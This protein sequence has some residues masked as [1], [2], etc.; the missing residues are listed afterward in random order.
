MSTNFKIA[1]FLT[2]AVLLAACEGDD[3]ANGVDGA[4]GTDGLNSLVAT[5]DIPK[6][7]A[8]CLGGGLALDSGLDTNRNGVLDADEVTATE[9]LE[10]EATPTARALHASPDAPAVNV[11]VN[12]EVALPGVDF[13]Q[14]SG[15]L[16]VIEEN[17]IEIE[18]IT[19][20]GNAV[21]LTI[22]ANLD[23]NTEATV[24]AVGKVADGTLDALAIVNPSDSPITAGSFRAQVVHGA[25]SAPPV[26][27]YV[28]TLDADLAGSAPVN[29]AGTPLAFG[30][31]TPQLEVT[32]GNYQVR[33]TAAGDPAAVV[34][35]SGEFSFGEGA[36]LMIVA[37]D[38]T[39]P[40]SSPVELVALDGTTGLTIKDA[41]TPASVVAAHLSP[42]APAVDILA[43]VNS[44]PEDEALKL[45]SNISFP[46]ACELGSVPAPGDYTI[47]VAANADNSVVPASFG[48][49]VEQS[50]EVTAIVSGFLAMGDP[51]IAALE[52]QIDDRRSIATETKLRITHASPSTGDVDL[53]LV[54]AGTDINNAE[55]AFP[56]VPF[57]AETTQ[58]SIEN[59][60][61]DAYV[62][63][64]GTKT[65]AI[66][67]TGLDFTAGGAVL[68]VIARD[69][70][71]GETGPQAF[72]ID[73]SALTP[74]PA[75]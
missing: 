37:V 9:F 4:D 28:T 70:A 64:A 10:C 54:P 38:N 19:P 51:V 33:V 41:N 48:L 45:T 60:M 72:V 55:P 16:P 12:G 5:R 15:F 40:G 14:G 68:N 52:P 8:A 26:D 35:D 30:A 46:A 25:P 47:N 56:G 13:G 50:S 65:A 39:G 49:E 44:T 62:T 22:P 59:L 17:T 69:P 24:I 1:G 2:A 67:L 31:F 7:D 75:P 20:A 61:Y 74:C 63:P 21:V 6:G 32:A 18:A 3:G 27:V 58:L 73:Y 53:Y 42:D 29:G 36:D 23:Y 43:D 11:I 57:G 66:S 34:F 71:E